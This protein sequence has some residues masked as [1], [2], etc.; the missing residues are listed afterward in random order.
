V[1]FNSVPLQLNSLQ[2]PATNFI[3]DPSVTQMLAA[4]GT[5]SEA[6]RLLEVVAGLSVQ[7]RKA[8]N[9]IA[10]PSSQCQ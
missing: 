6:V 9:S 10:H 8:C 4:V 3:R 2:A 5:S 1:I 7:G